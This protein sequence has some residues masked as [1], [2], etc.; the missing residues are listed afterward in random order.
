MARP[1]S[2]SN[3]NENENLVAFK[4]PTSSHKSRVNSPRLL[5]IERSPTT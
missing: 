5:P 1:L 4:M 3:E 2:S